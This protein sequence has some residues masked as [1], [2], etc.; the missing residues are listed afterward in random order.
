MKTSNGHIEQRAVDEERLDA[1]IDSVAREM[2]GGE[3][4]GALRE[5][6]LERIEQ[7]RRRSSIAVPGWAWA[8]AA[9]TVVLAAATAIWMTAPAPGSRGSQPAVAEQRSGSPAVSPAI[10]E[11]QTAQAAP[12]VPETAAAPRQAAA[13][14]RTGRGVASRGTRAPETDAAEDLHRVPALADIEPLRF[15]TVGPDPLEIAA[16]TVAPFPAMTSIDI[17]GL[18]PDSRDIQSADP[19]KENSP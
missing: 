3:P 11:R 1:A 19:K 14:N 5:L 17:P 10:L 8:G 7:G 15:S 18:E 13:V 16:V 12:S 9:A 2:T 4:S 6:V